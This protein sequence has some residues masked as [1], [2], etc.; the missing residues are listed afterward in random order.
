MYVTSTS[1]A[2]GTAVHY[3]RYHVY[4]YIYAPAVAVVSDLVDE[5]AHHEVALRTSTYEVRTR[6]ATCACGCE[7]RSICL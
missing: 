2:Y 4:I 7:E 5:C 6:E 1:V 3:T